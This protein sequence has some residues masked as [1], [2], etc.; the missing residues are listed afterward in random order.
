MTKSILAAMTFIWLQLL[1]SPA[2]SQLGIC[3]Y[4]VEDDYY[5]YT[6][7]IYI[8][9]LVGLGYFFIKGPGKDWSA[10]N[11]WIAFAIWIIGSLCIGWFFDP[12]ECNQYTGQP[13]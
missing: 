8:I 10:E 4:N 5:Y 3:R 6:S 13:Y 9:A 11:P 2:Y 1:S 12:G 7:Y